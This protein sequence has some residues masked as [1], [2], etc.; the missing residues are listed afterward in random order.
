MHEHDQRPEQ[1]LVSPKFDFLTFRK[2]GREGRRQLE[3][4]GKVIYD[5]FRPLRRRRQGGGSVAAKATAPPPPWRRLRRRQGGGFAAAKAA[6]SPPSGL[7]LRRRRSGGSNAANARTVK[8][9][10]GLNPSYGPS[11]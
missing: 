5:I 8:L 6:A 7:R 2:R 4:H 11:L 10:G 9:G 3:F 1:L